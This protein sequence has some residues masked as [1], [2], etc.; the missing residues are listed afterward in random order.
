MPVFSTS[1]PR[2]ICDRGM[3]GARRRFARRVKRLTAK[4]IESF[5]VIEIDNAEVNKSYVRLDAGGVFSGGS[6]GKWG[7][8]KGTRRDK[9]QSGPKAGDLGHF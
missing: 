5:K 7:G 9:R 6:P 4:L 2:D 8:R 3:A 1:N